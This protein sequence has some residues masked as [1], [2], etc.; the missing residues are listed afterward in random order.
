MKIKIF[1]IL[2]TI[3]ILGMLPIFLGQDDCEVNEK[4]EALDRLIRKIEAKLPPSPGNSKTYITHLSFADALTQ[5]T[6]ANTETAELIEEVIVKGL[7]ELGKHISIIAVNE[8]GHMI[9]NNDENVNKLINITLDPYLT[10]DQKIDRIIAE[11]M[12]PN[13]VDIIVTGHYIDDA[14]NQYISVRP[15]V[16][17]KAGKKIL[18]KNIQ[19]SKEEIFCRVPNSDEITLCRNAYDQIVQAFMELLEEL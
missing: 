18:T 19:F 7:S 6:M 11:L 14:K 8:T 12:E 15:L 3:G 13:H 16:I 2:T 1:L 9:K 17:V 4:S 5:S 10:K